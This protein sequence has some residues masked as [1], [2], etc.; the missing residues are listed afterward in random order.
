MPAPDQVRQFADTLRSLAT[1][2]DRH[3]AEQSDDHATLGKR[4]LL[5]VD[6]LGSRGPSRMGELAD[7]LGVG[8]SA[9]TPLVDRLE[10]HGAVRRRRSD[11]DRRVWLAE[12]TDEGRHIFETE[13]EAY[14]R[15]ASAMLAPLDADDRATLLTLLDRVGAGLRRT[16][17]G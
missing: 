9:I 5:A 7:W 6:V 17:T 10:A 11:A 14:E 16:P 2:F 13:R 1:L 8:Q 12:L 15:V 3:A 4:D